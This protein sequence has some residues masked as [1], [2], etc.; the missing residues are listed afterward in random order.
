MKLSFNQKWLLSLF[1]MLFGP[2]AICLNAEFSPKCSLAGDGSAVAVWNAIDPNGNTVI[3]SGHMS[4]SGVWSNPYTLSYDIGHTIMVNSKPSLYSNN[5]GDVVALW[6]YFD[7]EC[8]GMIAASMLPFGA[9]VWNTHVISSNLE[10]SLLEDHRLHIN[11]N[12]NILLLWSSTNRADRSIKK[13]WSST[14]TI[15]TS[16]TWSTQINIVP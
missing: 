7:E 4:S 10:D 11:E 13:I 2:Y 6:Q 12:G 8:C 15:G 14:S 3:Q 9:T 1:L 16:S 5:N